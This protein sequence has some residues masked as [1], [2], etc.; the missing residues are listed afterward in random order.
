[1]SK[2]TGV[3]HYSFWWLGFIPFLIVVSKILPRSLPYESYAS[4]SYVC[5]TYK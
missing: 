3:V 1:M 5:K 2:D 4:N